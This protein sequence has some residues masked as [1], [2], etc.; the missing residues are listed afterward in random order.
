MNVLKS[1]S[2]LSQFCAS[3]NFLIEM[4][5]FSFSLLNKGAECLAEH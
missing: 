4:P 5:I 1:G 2:L 3:L